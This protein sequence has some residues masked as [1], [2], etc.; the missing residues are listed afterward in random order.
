MTNTRHKR[1]WEGET[2][3]EYI[4]QCIARRRFQHPTQQ[5]ERNK[6]LL[7][8]FM[9]SIER[10]FF[11]ISLYNEN[12]KRFFPQSPRPTLRPQR[13]YSQHTWLASLTGHDSVPSQ[14][15]TFKNEASDREAWSKWCRLNTSRRRRFPAP[16]EGFVR[17]RRERGTDEGKEGERRR[18]V[19]LKGVF[20]GR[21]RRSD[22]A[23]SVCQGRR[24]RG[25][26]T[27]QPDLTWYKLTEL[28]WL[29]PHFIS[30]LKSIHGFC[31]FI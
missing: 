24:Q 25:V 28:T 14:D 10:L 31:Y 12:N 5:P 1:Q 6:I 15:L 21:D 23:V 27:R 18:S 29:L 22:D 16:E 26:E 2:V 20:W 4:Y 19:P 3:C 8:I 9:Y 11:S 17:R 7:R 30:W 13:R